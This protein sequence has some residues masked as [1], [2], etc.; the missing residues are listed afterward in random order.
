MGRLMSDPKPFFHAMNNA[1]STFLPP[2]TNTSVNSGTPRVPFL[3]ELGESVSADRQISANP[4]PLQSSR[5][6][7]G[8]NMELGDSRARIYA[9]SVYLNNRS[10][11][12]CSPNKTTFAHTIRRITAS[13]SD[14]ST[15]PPPLQHKTSSAVSAAHST[16]VGESPGSHPEQSGFGDWFKSHPFLPS[17]RP[18]VNSYHGLFTPPIYGNN[19]MT[20]PS[21]QSPTS[22]SNAISDSWKPNTRRMA[23]IQKSG[24]TDLMSR[25]K[26]PLPMMFPKHPLD[27][28]SA[29]SSSN[30]DVFGHTQICYAQSV[31]DD[32]SEDAVQSDHKNR[33][34]KM[35]SPRWE[36]SKDTTDHHHCRSGV[37]TFSLSEINKDKGQSAHPDEFRACFDSMFYQILEVYHQMTQLTKMPGV[38]QMDSTSK[39]A[40]H[41]LP[42]ER[43]SLPLSSQYSGASSELS[44][45]FTYSP[46]HSNGEP[47]LSGKDYEDRQERQSSSRSS[48]IQTGCKAEKSINSGSTTK[49][50]SNSR[51]PVSGLH[52]SRLYNCF[53][54]AVFCYVSF[55]ST[56][57]VHTLSKTNI[58]VWD[59]P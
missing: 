38:G 18:F 35:K 37:P 45:L 13:D 49:T 26:L 29:P 17:I 25:W 2:G 48:P 56:E 7:A 54:C 47:V 58:C 51:S 21:M 30:M 22:G 34:T 33:N 23:E 28:S 16:D 41:S 19:P 53:N 42:C 55:R 10:S 27:T 3:S 52:F 32:R 46:T 39:G 5:S 6:L 11:P 57:N 9:S 15:P 44:T 20:V 1:G 14:P 31:K 59:Q 4:A 36:A 12:V 24:W 40:G 43:M 8:E 50:D